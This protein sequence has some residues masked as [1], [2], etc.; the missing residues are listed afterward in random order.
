M[1][2]KNSKKTSEKKKEIKKIK[3]ILSDIK[4]S[5]NNFDVVF[6]V[7]ATD[8]MTSYIQSAKDETKNIAKEL[9]NTYTNKNFKYGY[10]FYRDPIDSASDI[11][12]IIDLT[13]DVDLITEKL[14]KIEAYGGGDYPED[15]AGAYKL[16]IEKITWRDGIKLIIHLADD[17]AHGKLFTLDDNYPEEEQKLINELINCANKGIR[18]FGYVIEEYCRRSFNEA[19]KIYRSKGGIFEVFKFHQTEI[20]NKMN[21]NNYNNISSNNMNLYDNFNNNYDMSINNNNILNYNIDFDDY[22]NVQIMNNNCFR[23]NALDAINRNMA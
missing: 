12:E 2:F 17:G 22:S 20:V 16:A 21:M 14:S 23:Y 11:H 5:S 9:K 8:S 3:N 10:I 19:S 13:D 1:E 4:P 18:I 15:W 6:L 7:D